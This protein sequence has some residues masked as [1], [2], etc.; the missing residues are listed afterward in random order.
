MAELDDW[1]VGADAAS[2][3]WLP[4]IRSKWLIIIPLPQHLITYLWSIYHHFPLAYHT[5]INAQAP[6]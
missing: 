6:A 2:E 5:P 4:L 1:V 3:S